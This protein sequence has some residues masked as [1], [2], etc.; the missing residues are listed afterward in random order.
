MDP[1][2]LESSPTPPSFWCSSGKSP[3]QSSLDLCTYFAITDQTIFCTYKKHN[4]FICHWTNKTQLCWTTW[5]WLPGAISFS[6]VSSSPS[7]HLWRDRT[8][9]KPIMESQTFDPLR[10]LCP[11]NQVAQLDTPLHHLP[12]VDLLNYGHWVP[13]ML[14]ASCLLQSSLCLS[15]SPLSSSI[16]SQSWPCLW[17][18]H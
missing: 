7:S 1:T 15:S 8:S 17:N 13:W 6:P 4:S 5:C 14:L 2:G 9:I 3:V 12:K 16:L 10:Y 11:T 18:L